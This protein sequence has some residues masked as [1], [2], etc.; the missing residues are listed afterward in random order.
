M[1]DGGEG[2]KKLNYDDKYIQH[3]LLLISLGSP[4]I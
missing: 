2:K 4:L 3:Q 1:R